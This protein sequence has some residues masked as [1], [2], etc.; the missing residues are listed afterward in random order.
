MNQFS[1]NILVFSVIIVGM[2]FLYMLSPQGDRSNGT[3]PF[4]YFLD[5][6]D[7]GRITDAVLKGDSVYFYLDSARG[8][9]TARY[10]NK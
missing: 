4:S 3:Q 6:L 7:Q 9:K 10:K 5:R 2:L 1:K 8:E